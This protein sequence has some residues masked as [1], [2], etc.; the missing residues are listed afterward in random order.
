MDGRG[1]GEGGFKDTSQLRAFISGT[2]EAGGGSGDQAG[3]GMIGR[4][5]ATLSHR[6]GPPWQCQADI[7][8]TQ[9]IGWDFRE[10]C[11]EESS[12]RG[13]QQEGRF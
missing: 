3:A 10:D 12:G 4:A 13:W 5:T 11:F 6:V 2:R 8:D 9:R 7:A 1:G